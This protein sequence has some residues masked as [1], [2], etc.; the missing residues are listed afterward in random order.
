MNQLTFELLSS[1]YSLCRLEPEE[2]VPDWVYLSAF[3]SIT[4]SKHELSIVCEEF[5]VPKGI[6]V[7]ESWRLL[8]I[9]GTLDLSLTGI[10]AKFSTPLA[11]AGINICVIATY[12]T[13]YLMVKSDKIL[14]TLHTLSKAGFGIET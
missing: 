10:T 6:T 1:T 9:T 14:E 4:K 11:E 12:D 13:D 5:L 2:G 8:R 7:E 3:F